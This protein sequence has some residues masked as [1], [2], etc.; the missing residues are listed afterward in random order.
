MRTLNF[1]FLLFFYN[2]L[3]AQTIIWEENFDIYSDGTTTG[4]LNRWTSTCSACASGDFFEVRSGAF[5]GR[6][7][8]DFSTWESESIDISTHPMVSFSL[9]AIENGDHEG[10]GC[11]CGINI[12]YFDVYY[13]IDGGVF[14]VI[15]N[16]NGDG[17][18]DHTLTGDVKNGTFTDND[19]ESTTVV[20]NGL[21]GSSLII[22]VVIRNTSGSENLILDNVSVFSPASPSCPPTTFTVSPNIDCGLA[23]G[24]AI[25]TPP[26]SGYSYLWSDPTMQ[27]DSLATNLLPDSTYEV[28]ITHIALPHCDTTISTTIPSIRNTFFISRA[29]TICDGD[30]ILVG[31]CWDT[32]LCQNG[33][34]SWVFPIGIG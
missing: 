13:S 18:I 4:N 20:Q 15:E 1:L 7:V 22:R 19:W 17:D 10:P 28:T 34:H 6:D 26:I 23:T 9:D 3:Y 32:F 16:W 21:S 30:S 14:T 5:Q 12:D 33:C 29:L 8:N 2:T 27:T 31:G 11:L 25:V 24:S